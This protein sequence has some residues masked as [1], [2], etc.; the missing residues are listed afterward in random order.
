M[1]VV[2]VVV[3]PFL[4]LSLS[5]CGKATCLTRDEFLVI[6][7]GDHILI[8]M[9]ILAIVLLLGSVLRCTT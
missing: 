9:Y 3:F 4:I 5:Q 8:Y 6:F 2:V 7:K 1:L